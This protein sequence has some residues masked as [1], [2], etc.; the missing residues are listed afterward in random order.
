[1]EAKILLA[2][3]ET[4]SHRHEIFNLLCGYARGKV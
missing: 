1:M 4:F 2:P 3:T